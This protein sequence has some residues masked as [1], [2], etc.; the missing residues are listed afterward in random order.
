MQLTENFNK[1][2]FECK[3]GSVMPYSVLQNVKELAKNLQ[4][5]RDYLGVPI[6]LTN[7]YRSPHYNDVVLPSRGYKTSKNS[8]H[9]KGKA[10]DIKAQ[11]KSPLQVKSA[12]EHLIATGKMKQGG[13][14]IY[15]TFIHYDIRGY[16][17]R[18][19]YR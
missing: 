3:D 9:K 17:A 15:K 19:D 14:G 7:G 2:E 11:G 4:V 16:R 18:W 8:Q 13:V 5:L 10:G 1:S 6:T 12:I